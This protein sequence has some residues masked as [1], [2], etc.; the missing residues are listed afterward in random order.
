MAVV[1][2]V[3]CCETKVDHLESS[4]L[5]F[6]LDEAAN[7]EI[8]WLDVI[9]DVATFMDSFKHIN[10]L[11][12]NS[13]YHWRRKFFCMLECVPQRISKSFLDN[14]APQIGFI[15]ISCYVPRK[16]LETFIID[17]SLAIKY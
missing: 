8:G 11:Y 10:N 12:T 9:V 4:G 2:N 7:D 6:A 3:L 5:L 17:H 13:Q 16:S 15:I 14:K 1:V